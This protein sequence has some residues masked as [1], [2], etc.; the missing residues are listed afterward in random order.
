MKQ[1]KLYQ[2]LARGWVLTIL[3]LAVILA[4]NSV[5]AGCYADPEIF[6]TGPKPD[7]RCQTINGNAEGQ[8]VY[9]CGSYNTGNDLNPVYEQGCHVQTYW[10][11]GPCGGA[12]TPGTGGY[13]CDWTQ[14]TC[15]PGTVKD[16]SQ[17]LSTY[18][19]GITGCPNP[20]SA[21][22]PGYNSL[23]VNRKSNEVIH[24]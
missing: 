18:C 15:P 22:R 4:P 24:V 1:N 23:I 21:R 12:G 19:G 3:V 10:C 8:A 9:N 13:T 17:M 14:S 5:L 20:G 16:T 2:I 6:V 11:D 7:E